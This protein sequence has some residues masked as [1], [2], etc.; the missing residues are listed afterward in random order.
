MA[1]PDSA[2][3]LW[4]VGVVCV[5][6]LAVSACSDGGD[7]ASEDNK[8]L[9][10]VVAEAVT[11]KDVSNET[12]FVGQTRSSQSVDIQARVKGT[13]LERPFVEGHQVKEGEVLYKIDPSEFEA[14]LLAANATL[15]KAQASSAEK[16]LTLSRY[17]A[18]V[19]K[20]SPGVSEAQ[21]DVALSQA[22]QA[23]AEVSAGKA[24][25]ANAKLDLGYATITSPLTGRAGIS[26][27]DVGNIIGPES[28]VLV[29]V[30]ALDPIEVDFSV[31][32]RVYLSYME[33]KQAGTAKVFTPRIRL[34]D[35]KLYPHEGELYVVNNEVDPA[36][37]TIAIRLKFPNPDRLLLPGQYVTVL[38]TDEKPEKQIVVPQAAVQQNQSGPFVLVVDG[39]D[40][41]QSRAIKTAQR[42]GTGIVVTD[43]LV[44]GQTIVVEGIQKVRPGAKVK[45][46]YQN[47]S[48]TAENVDDTP[49]GEA[50]SGAGGTEA[51][52]EKAP[53]AKSEASST[54]AKQS[55]KPEAEDRGKAQEEG[56]AQPSSGTDTDA[57]PASQSAAGKD[58]KA[59]D[60]AEAKQ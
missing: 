60:D 8:P 39:N 40:Q 26:T 43:G 50:T 34:A 57:K 45:V 55:S 37:G 5:L 11:E 31:G 32:E 52:A 35:G 58:G 3:G 12:T 49:A 22:K 13:L 17:Q 19:D 6:F 59:G 54:P 46:T 15:A 51:G 10:G 20:N 18:L 24:D 14:N 21:Y 38:L 25:V 27:V 56:N 42:V 48:G 30:L 36:T 44:P 7:K 9:P 29:T 28:G 53:G 2:A 16:N 33:A 23:D 41:V 1:Q 4:K 47:P